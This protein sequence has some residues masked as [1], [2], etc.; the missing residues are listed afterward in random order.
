MKGVSKQNSTYIC[1][2][3]ES[4]SLKRKG[5][6]NVKGYTVHPFKVAV[7]NETHYVDGLVWMI[8]VKHLVRCL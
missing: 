1:M 5:A 7:S 4:C 2:G 3:R 6:F 8:E